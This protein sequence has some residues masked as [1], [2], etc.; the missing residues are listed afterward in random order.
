VKHK[1]VARTLFDAF[2]AAEALPRPD[3]EDSLRAIRLVKHKAVA[4]T[5][6]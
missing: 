1:A 3:R 5:Q 6:Y 2:S 4:R